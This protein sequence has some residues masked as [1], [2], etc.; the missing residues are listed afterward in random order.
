MSIP[1][2]W[3]SVLSFLVSFSS[4]SQV[5]LPPAPVSGAM[6]NHTCVIKAGAL[7]CWG[8]NDFGQLGDGTILTSPL[9]VTII[10]TAVT[11]ASIGPTH[12]CAIAAGVL[13]CWGDNAN[14]QLGIGEDFAFIYLPYKVAVGATAVAVGEKHTCAIIAKV[15]KCWGSDSDGQIGDDTQTTGHQGADPDADVFLPKNTIAIAGAT[16]I[17]SGANHSCALSGTSLKCWGRNVEGQLALGDEGDDEESDGDDILNTDPT[18][19]PTL[20]DTGLTSVSLGRN[21]SCG[22]IAGKLLCAGANG[23]GQLG[24]GGTTDNSVAKRV[25]YSGVSQVEA[26]ADHTCALR[27][28]ALK[29]WGANG[30]SQVGN[31]EVTDQET[32]VTIFGLNVT[33]I[34]LGAAHTC[35]ILN[36]EMMCVGSNSE[37]QLGDGS[38]DDSDDWVFPILQ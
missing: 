26:G 3:I 19:L 18:L 35:A 17:L 38:D 6:A 33:G 1:W 23:N 14:G 16:K 37:G 15:V 22:V 34:S 2:K 28:G 29:C 25:M 24:V 31:G 36:K 27:F 20:V 5:V 11:A 7:I 13:Y 12:S 10:T 8:A 9:P 21:H 32:P 4:F 30:S